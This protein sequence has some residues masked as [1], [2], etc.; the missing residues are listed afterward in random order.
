[1]TVYYSRG[2]PYYKAVSLDKAVSLYKAVFLYKAVSLY[3]AVPL[4]KAVK[5]AWRDRGNC[6]HGQERAPMGGS[7]RCRYSGNQKTR[8]R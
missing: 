8:Q 4:C 5:I 6:T 2:F 1:M 3:K 7:S